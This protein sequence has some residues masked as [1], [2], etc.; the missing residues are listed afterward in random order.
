MNLSM[1]VSILAFVLYIGGGI[2]SFS[3]IA[4]LMTSRPTTGFWLLSGGVLACIWGVLALRIIRN[5]TDR[6]LRSAVRS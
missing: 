5:R 6:L 1:P 4:L 2:A 3:G